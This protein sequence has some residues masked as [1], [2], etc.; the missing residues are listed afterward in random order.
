MIDGVGPDER[1]SVL[2]VTAGQQDNIKTA[3]GEA[4]SW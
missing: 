1:L 3:S 2:E 4:S